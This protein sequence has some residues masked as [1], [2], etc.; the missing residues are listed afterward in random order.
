MNTNIFIN[1]LNIFLI[2]KV[3]HNDFYSLQN[4]TNTDLIECTFWNS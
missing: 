2:Y 3:T 4:K 1:C